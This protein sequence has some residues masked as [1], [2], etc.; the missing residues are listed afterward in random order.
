M[1]RPS[2][3]LAPLST[4]EDALQ[5]YEFKSENGLDELVIVEEYG[6]ECSLAAS[7]YQGSAGAVVHLITSN[8]YK[9]GRAR[10]VEVTTIADDIPVVL[11]LLHGLSCDSV[12]Y[13][14]CVK[15]IMYKKLTSQWNNIGERVKSGNLTYSITGS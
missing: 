6:F 7:Y 8:D 9:Y 14:P 2:F 10:G 4:N 12:G 11:M 1:D 3:Q 15:A 5:D 13:F